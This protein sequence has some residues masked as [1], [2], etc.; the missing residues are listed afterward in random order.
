MMI[1]RRLTCVLAVGLLA[2]TVSVSAID[3]TAKQQQQTADETA[4]GMNLQAF[5][6]VQSTAGT[7]TAERTR[8]KELYRQGKSSEAAKLLQKAVKVNKAD[9]EAWYYLGLAFFHQPKKIKDAAKAF[10]T[11]VKLRPQFAAA[12]IGLAYTHLRRNKSA[13]AVRV[14]RTALNIDPSL[15]EP[16]HIIGVVRLNAG[17]PD[18][19]LTEAREAIRLNSELPS[20]YRL[21]SQALVSIYAKRT[22][23]S[24]LFAKTSSSPQTPEHRAERHKR[25]LES[26][27]VFKEAAESLD[28]YLRL[29]P[30]S[31]SADH[32]RE[33]LVSLKFYGSYTGDKTNLDDAPYSGDEVTTK[34]RVLSKPEPAYTE[35]AREALVTG[36]VVLRAVLSADGSVRHILVLAGLPNGLT[37]TAVRAA[38]RIKFTPATIDGRPVSTFVQMEYNFNLY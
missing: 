38:R 3:N 24:S 26:T 10:E 9:D 31:S 33:Q 15:A 14:S 22:L 19:A 7:S 12:H 2:G 16:H 13:E 5:H 11:A 28:T 27:A 35:S 1:V 23:A 17:E 20:A 29:D 34:A 32:L 18:E 21:K 6:S 37:E 25:R 4:R 30:S 8:G 36:T